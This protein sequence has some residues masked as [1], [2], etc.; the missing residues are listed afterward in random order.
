LREV[1]PLL[2]RRARARQLTASAWAERA[3]IRKETLSRLARRDNCDLVTLCSLAHAVGARLAVLDEAQPATTPD[4][5]FPAQLDRD[6]EEQLV[7]LCAARDLDPGRWAG[8]GPRFFVAGLAVMT[9]SLPRVDRG[10]LLALAEQLHP[11]ASDVAVFDRW[12][13]RS[14][15]RPSRFLPLLEAR[16]ARA[17]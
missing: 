4:G 10:G 13:E 8:A 5:H 2:A 3:G 14:P 6:Y 11:G 16:L 12:L 15:V 9:A 7:E 1:L 17:P